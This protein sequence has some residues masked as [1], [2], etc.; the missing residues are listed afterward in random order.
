MKN[1]TRVAVLT[2][3]LFIASS[4]L[5]AFA[6]LDPGTGSLVLQAVITAVAFIMVTG[7]L[8]WN[9]FCDFMGFRKKTNMI[10][11]Q[12]TEEDQDKQESQVS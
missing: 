11:S 3:V 1:L 4:Q 8:W 10:I 9:R 2:V 7:K 12:S 6:Y 5:S